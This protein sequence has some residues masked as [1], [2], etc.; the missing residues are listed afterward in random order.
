MFGVMWLEK[1]MTRLKSNIVY[2]ILKYIKK[3]VG[4]GYAQYAE[5]VGKKTLYIFKYIC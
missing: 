5:T 2:A 3:C 4:G 1:K